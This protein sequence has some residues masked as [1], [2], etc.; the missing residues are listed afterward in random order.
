MYFILTLALQSPLEKKQAKE[1]KQLKRSYDTIQI[2]KD[3]DYAFHQFVVEYNKSYPTE[4]DRQ[5]AREQFCL[6]LEALRKIRREDN[7]IEVGINAHFDRPL[8]SLV[9]GSLVG[10]EQD[11]SDAEIE[12]K[13]FGSSYGAYDSDFSDSEQSVQDYNRKISEFKCN[14]SQSRRL[15]EEI[16]NNG[17]YQIEPPLSVDLREWGMIGK[18]LDQGSCGSCWAMT[19]R[20]VMQ[21]SVLHDAYYYRQIYAEMEDADSLFQTG[22]LKLS[23]QMILND[24][25]SNNM[26]CGGGNFENAAVDSALGRVPSQELESAVPY[27]SMMWSD[28]PGTPEPIA[29]KTEAFKRSPL[30]P[31]HYFNSRSENCANVLFSVSTEDVGGFGEAEVRKIKQLLASGVVLAGQMNTEAGS[32]D[33]A[34]KFQLYRSGVLDVAPCRKVTSNHQITLAGYGHYKGEPVWLWLNSWG[35]SWGQYGYFMTRVGSNAFCTENAVSGV[36]PRFAGYDEAFSDPQRPFNESEQFKRMTSEGYVYNL[37]NRTVHRDKNG[38]DEY[39]DGVPNNVVWALPEGKWG[40]AGVAGAFALAF[41]V[42]FFRCCCARVKW[43]YRI[44]TPIYIQF[45]VEEQ[46]EREFLNLE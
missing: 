20:Y 30:I 38:L 21:S 5:A 39:T 31:V 27:D 45:P 18:A 28:D 12:R 46:R 32:S 1:L 14:T 4:E 34:N 35:S 17:P 44:R 3:C 33:D 25:T 23:V 15:N 2:E 24:S 7:R 11:I 16:L 13:S 42:A 36:F 10:L 29:I 26:M 37:F 19:T 40:L 22:N 43:E 8:Q 9:T 41:L 6:H